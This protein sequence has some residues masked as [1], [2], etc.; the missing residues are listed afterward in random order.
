MKNR[1]KCP[2]EIGSKV[3]KP[4]SAPNEPVLSVLRQFWQN[5]DTQPFMKKESEK[6]S[7]QHPSVQATEP[8]LHIFKYSKACNGDAVL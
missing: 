5:A 7:L 2:S 4:C 3:S 1:Y 8:D 6:A